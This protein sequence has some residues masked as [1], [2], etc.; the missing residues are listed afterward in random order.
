[1][2]NG[3]SR[4]ERSSIIEVQWTKTSSFDHADDQGTRSAEDSGAGEDW[5]ILGWKK[6]Y[7][8]SPNVAM[9]TRPFCAYSVWKFPVP[10]R[11]PTEEEEKQTKILGSRSLKDGTTGD[12]SQ[13]G[14]SMRHHEVCASG[15]GPPGFSV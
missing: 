3:R 2:R 6:R 10:L 8:I 12:R 7:I 9:G 14:A 15:G 5:L 11:S 4:A 1:M 13:T